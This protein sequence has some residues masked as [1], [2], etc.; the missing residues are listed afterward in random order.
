MRVTKRQ[1]RRIIREEI[2]V[3]EYPESKGVTHF[4]LEHD[5]PADIEPE[6]DAWAGG[7][8][9]HK[10]LDHPPSAGGEKTVRGQEILQVVD[11][12]LEESGRPLTRR[13][14]RKIVRRVLGEATGRPGG[15]S[16]TA[17]MLNGTAA[18]GP[19]AGMSYSDIAL[20]AIEEGDFRAAA[21]AVM[22]AL[23]IDDPW[24]ED[25]EALEEM[26]GAVG[27]NVGWG[28]GADPDH[29][30]QV[31]WEWLEKFR[32]GGYASEEQ[33]QGHLRTWGPA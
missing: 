9:I 14:L 23:W 25:E 33:K 32:A 2:E 30:A 10:Q 7:Q 12:P 22:G 11:H 17:S 18:G 4:D 29:L 28:K 16:Y 20:M 1:L 3:L 15:T 31:A 21:N 5:D 24:P 19:N 26:L 27:S 6:E 8:N 13:A